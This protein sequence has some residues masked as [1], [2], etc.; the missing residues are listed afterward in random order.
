MPHPGRSGGNKL[1]LPPGSGS[2]SSTSTRAGSDSR[3]PKTRKFQAGA[4]IVAG[5]PSRAPG[6]H[7][8]QPQ[9]SMYPR[10]N[11][12]TWVELWRRRIAVATASVTLPVS[13]PWGKRDPS[14]SVRLN[15]WTELAVHFNHGIRN[16]KLT[17][18]IVGQAPN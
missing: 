6:S 12:P 16:R 4:K 11:L 2:K 13:E 18:V 3:P 9:H 7:V 10:T 14:A 5:L 17:F 1:C 15:T 8:L